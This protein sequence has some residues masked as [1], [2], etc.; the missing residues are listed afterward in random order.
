M[1]F[2]PALPV[3]PVAVPM[4]VAALLAAI[5][6]WLPRFAVDMLACLAALFNVIFDLQLLYLSWSRNI[7]Y[8]FG[9]WFPRGHMVIGI[10]FLVDPVGAALAF[11]AAFL[12]LLGLLYSWGHMDSGRNLFQPLMLIFL[13]AMSG[14]CFTADLFNLFVFFELMSTAA[15]ALC[16]LK[17]QEPSPLQ[18]SF[19]FAI[20]NTTGAF[21]ILTGIALLYAVT[22]ALN[23]AQMGSL[24]A[25][26]H[27]SLVLTACLF[28]VSGFLIKAAIVP[29]H[30]W[31]PDAHSVAPTPVC[32][33]FSGIMVEL[34]LFAI[35]RLAFVIFGSSF[36]GVPKPLQDCFLVLGGIT[37]VWGGVMCFAEHHLKRLLAFSTISHSGMMLFAMGLNSRLAIAGWLIYVCAHAVIKSG[38][39]FTAG[40]LLHRLRSMSEPVLFGRGKILRFTAAL[41]FLGGCGLAGLPPFASA[42]AE[43]MISHGAHSDHEV[44]ATILFFISGILTGGA[45]F[46]VFMRVFCG[47]GDSGPSDRSAQ[48]DELPETHQEQRLITLRI[49]GPAALCVISGIGLT[50]LPLL[51]RLSLIASE[52]F[53]NQREYIHAIYALP[54]RQPV[55]TPPETHLPVVIAHGLIAVVCALLL[56]AWAVFHHR[57]PRRMRWPSHLEGSMRWARQLQSGQPADYV[58]YAMIGVAVIGSVL[59]VMR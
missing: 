2:S 7:V 3:L 51:K 1:T 10:G 4:L 49:F 59:F 31:L 23:M 35:L 32:V 34:G 36:A 54:T 38:L 48:I 46:R 42:F 37:A 41:W 44:A 30:F 17:V 5:R 19:N 28:I 16:G 39:F 25:T 8:W 29:F 20:T 53:L 6:K 45:V 22:G 27:D 11:V 56:A 58:T 26:R 40:I 24:L 15:F 18:G 12:T 43:D 55:V 14:F 47:W 33:L 52:R 57:L 50:F 9:N 13:A 21:L